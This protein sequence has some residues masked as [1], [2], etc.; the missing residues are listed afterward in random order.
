MRLT[1]TQLRRII[2]EEVRKVTVL[3]E[4][5][6]PLESEISNTQ[7]AVELARAV[8]TINTDWGS[9]FN[10]SDPSM[11]EVGEDAWFEQV[12]RAAEDLTASIAKA[13]NDVYSRLHNGEYYRDGRR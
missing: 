12:D 1:P 4:D 5:G 13:Y 9:D 11:A 7:H 6:G 2:E 10:P 3:K 8:S